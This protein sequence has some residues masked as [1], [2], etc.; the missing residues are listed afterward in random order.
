MSDNKNPFE[1]TG[2]AWTEYKGH[3]EKL[4][5]ELFSGVESSS[6]ADKKLIAENFTHGKPGQYT[7]HSPMLLRKVAHVAP[8]TLT[9]QVFSIIG[10]R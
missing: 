8:P 9:E 10:H 2:A 1:L 3:N 5:D 4:I 7:A 6:A